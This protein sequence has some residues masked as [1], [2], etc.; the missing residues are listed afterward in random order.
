[1]DVSALGAGDSVSTTIRPVQENHS[2]LTIAQKLI[3]TLRGP[4]EGE[5]G[6]AQFASDMAEVMTE[7][8]LAQDAV[9][10]A[11]AEL[12]GRMVM[13]EQQQSINAEMTIFTQTVL[14]N[15]ED[16]DYAAA[17]S[18]FSF[19]EVALQAAQQTFARVNQLSLFNYL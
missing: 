15:L 2:I 3:D 1:M 12:G 14:S 5:N 7:V 10:S 6:Q 13:L 18:K 19:Q 11:H 9:V 8:D 17:I 16:L 4:I